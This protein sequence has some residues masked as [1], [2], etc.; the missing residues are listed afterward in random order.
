MSDTTFDIAVTQRYSEPFR[1]HKSATGETTFDQYRK[2]FEVPYREP[3]AHHEPPTVAST[4]Q[5]T[6]ATM[7]PAES[8]AKIEAK[9]D[10]MFAEFRAEVMK[11]VESSLAGTSSESGNDPSR[12]S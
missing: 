12:V 2:Q 5:S 7:T 6:A 8:L 10:A 4:P 11:A 3:S 1:E 9:I